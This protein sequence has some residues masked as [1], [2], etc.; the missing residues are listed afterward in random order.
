MP[1]H[2]KP[3]NICLIFR[4]RLWHVNRQLQANVAGAVTEIQRIAWEKETWLVQPAWEGHRMLYKEE[5]VFE[6]AHEPWE[7]FSQVKKG[8]CLSKGTG[9]R[10][11]NI[12]GSEL[13]IHRNNLLEQVNK[14]YLDYSKEKTA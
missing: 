1:V 10:K 13:F 4:A 8:Q 9:I 6:V 11:F 5:A 14:P 3:T 12:L 7:E 2:L